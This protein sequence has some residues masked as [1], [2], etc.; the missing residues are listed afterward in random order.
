[1]FFQGSHAHQLTSENRMKSLPR[2]FILLFV[3][4]TTLAQN[5]LSMHNLAEEQ[6]QAIDNFNKGMYGGVIPT[7]E[8]TTNKYKKAGKALEYLK[9]ADVLCK[10][11][12]YAG[13]YDL[14]IQTK[15]EQMDI[16]AMR[17]SDHD[18]AYAMHL[19]MLAHLYSVIGDYKIAIEYSDKALALKKEVFGEEDKEYGTAL[20]N[21]AHYHSLIGNYEVSTQ[22]LEKAETIVKK[23]ESRESEGYATYLNLFASI[24][25]NLTMYEEALEIEEECYSI[26]QN[27]T[28]IKIKPVILQNLSIFSSYCD[29]NEKAISYT[30][31]ALDLHKFNKTDESPDYGVALNNLFTF[32]LEDKKYNEAEKIG[33]EAFSFFNRKY[34]NNHVHIVTVLVNLSKLYFE[35][36]DINKASSYI[37]QATERYREIILDNFK[38]LT[39]SERN[40]YWIKS[41]PW[42]SFGLPWYALQSKNSSIICSAYNGILLTKG[43]LLNSEKELSEIV[44]NSGNKDAISLYTQIKDIN[45]KKI[46]LSLNNASEETIE[47]LSQE[48]LQKE[49]Q[50]LKICSEFGDFTKK[51]N[52]HW[53]DI[54]S[55]LKNGEVAIEFGE[56][57]GDYFAYVLKNNFNAPKFVEI[58]FKE[59][60]NTNINLSIT[61]W[62]NLMQDLDGVNNVYFA[63]EGALH[64]LPIE[65][66]PIPGTTSLMNERYNLYRLT[67]TREIVFR[68]SHYK[69][70][71]IVLYGGLDYD[72]SVAQME[73]DA[74]I[75][76]EQNSDIPKTRSFDFTSLLREASIG[77]P[78]LHGSLEEVQNIAKITEPQQIRTTV[79]LHEKGT[80]ASFKAL[81]SQKTSLLHIAT[82]GY[83]YP[84]ADSSIV[85][86]DQ[87]GLIVANNNMNVNYEDK[88]LL[89]SGLIMSGAQNILDEEEIP[90]YIDDGLLTAQEIANV[91]LEG[92]NLVTLSACET[93]K[94]DINGDGVFGLQRGF[95]KAGANSILMSLWKVDDAAT[96]KLMTEFYSNWIG[97]KMT[98]HDAL[99]SAKRAVRETKGWEDPKY[100]ASFILLDGLE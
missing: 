40:Y 14:A 7:L 58:D 88:V 54:K 9:G 72:C 62:G 85:N 47:K 89:R 28:D 75:Y 90:D 31:E 30:L 33:L 43:L 98:K 8:K 78:Y 86:N 39:K 99:E 97:Q 82:H 92:L 55:S 23:V 67:S 46:R 91:N 63:A 25:F 73:A 29:K 32:Y 66:L 26:Y 83:Y 87:L 79:L 60:V 95:K 27:H 96:C 93:A 81:T 18:E 44:L 51:L 69:N 76:R 35:K 52:I 56:Y 21:A 80:E 11:Y 70:G 49:N 20:L 100:W 45:A 17:Y 19:G 64:T 13:Q 12:E 74:E 38:T 42:F 2:I 22:Y 5:S 1:M 24:A 94:G 41:M 48:S 53:E 65:S 57:N 59:S 6:M 68:N 16:H 10:A 4:F 50:L 37:A 36:G 84:M 61:V 71:Q 34:K 3:S 77:F 15:K